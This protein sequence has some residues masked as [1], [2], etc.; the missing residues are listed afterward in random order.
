M[1]MKSDRTAF[2]KSLRIQLT[3]TTKLETD[4]GF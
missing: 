1:N 4:Q 2:K 3:V